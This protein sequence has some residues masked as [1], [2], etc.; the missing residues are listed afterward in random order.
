ME[1]DLELFSDGRC[2]Q[3]EIDGLAG[4]G[5]DLLN[6]YVWWIEGA[7]TGDHANGTSMRAS[8]RKGASQ[9]VEER[10]PTKLV[11]R[12]VPIALHVTWRSTCE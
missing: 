11:C 6:R 8:Q 5:V 7:I 3:L 12:G 4:R 2:Q 1:A 10:H 9:Y